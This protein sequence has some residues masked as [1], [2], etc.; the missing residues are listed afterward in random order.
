MTN[1]IN[2]EKNMVKTAHPFDGLEK[3]DERLAKA[4]IA[5]QIN[6]LIQEQGMTQKEAASLLGITQPEVSQLANGRLSDFT[7]DRLYRC[8]CALDM[9]I[10]IILKKHVPVDSE[11]AGIHVSNDGL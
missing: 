7:F 4:K 5:H 11:V 3:G 1:I 6:N 9:D 8:L 2:D 10:E